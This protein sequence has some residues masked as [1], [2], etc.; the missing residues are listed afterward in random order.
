MTN[1]LERMSGEN[2]GDARKAK[3]PVHIND[4]TVHPNKNRGDETNRGVEREIE[5]WLAPSMD[6]LQGATAT[7]R[8]IT[9]TISIPR[10][11]PSNRREWIT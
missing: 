1:L 7:G 4:G 8:Y 11:A 2:G 9:D 6:D 5:G 10:R 3:H